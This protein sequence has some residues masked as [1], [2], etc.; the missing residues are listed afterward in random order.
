MIMAGLLD[1]RDLKEAMIP[2]QSGD[3]DVQDFVAWGCK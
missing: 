2:S 3:V 1:W